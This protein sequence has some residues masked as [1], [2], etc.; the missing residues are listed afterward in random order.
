LPFDEAAGD[1]EKD[2]TLQIAI[3]VSRELPVAQL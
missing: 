3:G 2:R 1:A